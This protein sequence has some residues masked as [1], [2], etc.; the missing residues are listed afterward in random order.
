MVAASLSLLHNHELR[1]AIQITAFNHASQL[2]HNTSGL[3]LAL[4]AVVEP[5]P[6]ANG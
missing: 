4:E 2:M 6:H 5:E 3:Q 1:R